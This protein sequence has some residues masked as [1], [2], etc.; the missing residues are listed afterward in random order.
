MEV[1]ASDMKI[2]VSS[3]GTNL[4]SQIDPRFGRCPY[5]IIIDDDTMKFEALANSNISAMHGAGIGAAQVVANKNVKVV[6]TGNIGPNAYQVLSSTGIKIITGI[7]GKVKDA[8]EKFKSGELEENPQPTVAPHFGVG[9]GGG[10]G[11][12]RMGGKFSSHPNTTTQQLYSQQ[13]IAKS[14]PKEE[15]KALRDYKNKL[16]EELKG[17]EARIKELKDTIEK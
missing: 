6:I 12:K 7:T 10:M 11:M 14:E 4:E 13:P 5:F 8:I 15:I 9:R 3:S 2:C 17:L 1:G 16:E